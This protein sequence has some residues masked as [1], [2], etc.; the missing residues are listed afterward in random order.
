MDD[1][2]KEKPYAVVVAKIDRYA[3][4]LIDLLNSIQDLDMG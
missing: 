4:S 3:R 1:I 2:E